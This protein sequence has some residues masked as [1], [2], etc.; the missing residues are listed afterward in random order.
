MGI[1]WARSSALATAQ[2]RQL[3]ARIG[4]P[5]SG[6]W[7]GWSFF[8]SWTWWIWKLYAYNVP[9][10]VLSMTPSR[11]RSQSTRNLPLITR[12]ALCRLEVIRSF[13]I[14]SIP[15]H[16]HSAIRTLERTYWALNLFFCIA[17]STSPPSFFS[18]F[19]NFALLSSRT[20]HNHAGYWS[21]GKATGS[22]WSLIT[23]KPVNTVP[24]GHDDIANFVNSTLSIVNLIYLSLLLLVLEYQMKG[25]YMLYTV[26]AIAKKR[27]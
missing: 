26:F 8:F 5:G 3:A 14:C 6:G 2:Y 11:A 9:R 18:P 24:A 22:G 1:L 16:Q 4:I 17:K 20:V 15:I 27:Q 23:D 21:S 10:M 25:L 7:R 13:N 19:S 12:Q